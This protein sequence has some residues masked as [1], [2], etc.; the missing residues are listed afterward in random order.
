MPASRKT[1]K[2]TTRISM[3]YTITVSDKPYEVEIGDLGS[4]P[5]RVVVNGKEYNVEI[6]SG[7][8]ATAEAPGRPAMAVT[9]TAAAPAVSA[10]A[11]KPQAQPVAAASGNEVVA[12]MPGTILDVV[13]KDGQKVSH[14]QQ[15]CALEAMKMKS[16]IRS[17]R[18]GVISKVEV[19]NGQKV[20][21]GEVIVRFE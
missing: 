13:V 4:S 11:P 6:E 14:G 10:K 8:G 20:A 2:F 21:Y 19:I 5:V 1:N 9:T 18:E 7:G 15:I 3:K 17:P 16:A 12:P